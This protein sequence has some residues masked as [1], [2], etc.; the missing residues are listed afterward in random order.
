MFHSLQLSASN[1]DIR[2]LLRTYRC[3]YAANATELY[4][5]YLDAVAPINNWLELCGYCDTH[6]LAYRLP[7]SDTKQWMCGI[8]D[9]RYA[10]SK[11]WNNE[12][13]SFWTKIRVFFPFFH[14][15]E[16]EYIAALVSHAN[17]VITHSFIDRQRSLALFISSTA[18]D[19]VWSAK[20]TEIAYLIIGTHTDGDYHGVRAA[21]E[22]SNGIRIQWIGR[23][24]SSWYY[25]ILKVCV[26]CDSTDHIF[27]WKK[28][29]SEEKMYKRCVALFWWPT[30]CSNASLT[31]NRCHTQADNVIRVYNV[32]LEQR[33]ASAPYERC[34]SHRRR[35]RTCCCCC[36]CC[37]S[38]KR[39][40]FLFA[41]V[42]WLATLVRATW[43]N[44]TRAVVFV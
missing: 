31:W 29:F 18:A 12:D 43:A 10:D 4:N 39:G 7:S 8:S 32:Y 1:S 40:S 28:M 44:R 13:C 33:N 36:F 24:I 15:P 3:F 25:T 35:R 30:Q 34:R 11:P 16:R 17:C 6:I 38:L 19:F 27:K 41:L 2:I 14:S 9:A 23:P 21:M 26:F 22:L 5:N 20:Q 37:Y 42:A